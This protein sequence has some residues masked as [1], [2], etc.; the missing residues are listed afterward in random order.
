MDKAI[1]KLGIQKD[2]TLKQRFA[3]KFEDKKSE[4]KQHYLVMREA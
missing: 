4:N 3:A 1:E 2:G